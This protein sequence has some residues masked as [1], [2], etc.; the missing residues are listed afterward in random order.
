MKKNV[1]NRRDFLKGSAATTLGLV[2][3]RLPAMA[4]PFSREDFDRLV[5][6]NKKLSP[7]WVKSLF[8]RGEP[9]VLR[10]SEL[11]YVGMPVG[12]L[13]AG[14]LYLGGDGRLWHW[15]IFNQII[16]SGSSGPNYAKPPLPSSPL[17][18]RFSLKI[19]DAVHT[20]DRD[21]FAAITFRGE[22]PIGLV[23]YADA[24]VPL[25]AELEAFSPFI[26]LNTGDS[27]LPATILR[28]TL[29]NN[30][31]APVEATLAGELENGVCLNHRD[32]AGVLRNR[33]VR[34]AGLTALLCFAEKSATQP[35]ER[36]EII[37][38]DWNRENYDGWK[39]EGTAFGSGPVKKSAMPAYQGDVG[40]DTVRV[41][42][43]HATAPGGGIETK[44]NATGKLTSRE[45]IIER[46][47]ISF[48]IGGGKA[49]ADS[50]LGLHLVV[51]GKSVLTASGRDQNQMSRAHFDVRP[52]AGKVA[53]LEILDDATGGWGNVGVGKITFTDRLADAGP[54]EQLPDFGTMSLALL[55]EPA[56][57][58]CPDATVPFT[59]KLS[60]SLGR[61]F[62][63]APGESATVTFVVTWHF[64]N[65]S[66]AGPLKNAGRHYA[67]KFSSAHAV[68]QY[69]AA[70]FD[71]LA[72]E[73]RLWRDTWYDST[74]PFWFLDRTF[75]NASI[76]ATST[77]HRF[78]N[79]RYYGWEGVGCCE[80]TC[81]HVYHY[82]HACARLFP[83][84]ERDTRARVDFG[85]ALQPDGAI[86]FRG[87][88]NNFPAVDGQAGTILRALREHQMSADDQFLRHNWSKIKL[89]TQWL[90][91][92]DANNDGLIESNQHNTLDTDWFGKVAWLS[93]LYLAALAA[94]A[95]MAAEMGDADF[96]GQCRGILETG[97]KNFVAQLF[98]GDYFINLVDPNHLAAINSGTGC[99]IDQVMGQ[100]WAFQTGLPRVLP[101][102]ETLSALKSLWR[103]NFSPDVGPYRAAYQPGRWYAM[104]GEAGLLMCT[105]PRR[106]WDY[107]QAKGRGPDW[108]AGYFDE[109]MNG[110]EYEA[111]GHMIW[112]GL[113]LEGLAVTRAVHDR[114]HASRRNPWNEIEC[115]DHYARSM[116]SHGVFLAAGGFEYHGP[117]QHLG[118]AP[119]LS[120]ENFKCAFTSAEGWGSYSQKSERG[121]WRAEIAMRWGK[122][123]LKTI[124]LAM[125]D[126]S[127]IQVSLHQNVQPMKFS[128][129]GSR[130]LIT[131]DTAVEI[132]A[133]EVLKISTPG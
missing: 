68:A 66:L 26:P 54:L 16:G 24:S 45:F 70:Q 20:L 21:G 13:F 116:A 105:F 43:S 132:S 100:S 28:F 60:G 19:G 127:S 96:E 35:A 129:E 64:P 46:N 87:E 120:P 38:E 112:A 124:A 63:L 125:A 51:D 121:Q 106:D 109:C 74:L 98:D 14:Q 49:R 61:S 80:G 72:R 113:L 81:G 44:D 23:K 33:I 32:H 126:A 123:K 101:E 59:E 11:K 99:E 131:L 62:K 56:E 58:A 69:V 50:R 10:G 15:D 25:A 97:R 67:T 29:R 53:H 130:V 102:K 36:P 86:H 31:A 77:S 85:L 48:W 78:A 92:K 111:A 94:A 82:A 8:A 5:P 65:L 83:E 95:A 108:A 6:A 3:S 47:F 75:L 27:S 88:F 34:E 41:V 103:Y 91:A 90:I 17:A 110:F 9:E 118:F 7:D 73:T 12:G 122:L 18:Q 22:Y 107:A 1:W 37:F 114:Y 71:R 104:P 52:Y 57:E 39:V 30:S 89:A 128:R 55:G 115:G 84:L 79:G 117:K 4:G 42:N 40:G 119:R 133:G 93:G 76:L 2:L